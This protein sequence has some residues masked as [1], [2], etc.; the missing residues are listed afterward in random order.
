MKSLTT[1]Q[2]GRRSLGE[3]GFA[4]S[5]KLE[6]AIKANLKGLG[7]GDQPRV[8]SPKGARCEAQGNALGRESGRYQ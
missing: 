1:A 2:L 4:E 3:G 8:L 5:A 6:R 7:Y